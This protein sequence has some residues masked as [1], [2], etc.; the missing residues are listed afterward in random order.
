M[1]GLGWL[2]NQAGVHSDHK[3]LQPKGDVDPFLCGL[4]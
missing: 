2:L 1:E 3:I 4:L